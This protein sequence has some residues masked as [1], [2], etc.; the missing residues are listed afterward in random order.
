MVVYN[1]FD[2]NIQ[3]DNRKI[4]NNKINIF[5]WA[6]FRDW[7]GHSFLVKVIKKINKEN[8][9]FHFVA[10]IQDAESKRV[11]KALNLQIAKLDLNE[12]IEFHLDIPNH[13]GFIKNNAQIALSCS[14]LKDPLPTIL[15]ESLCLGIPI[16]STN[17][18]GS[19]E[20]LRAFPNFLSSPN[21]DEFSEKLNCIIN[22][23]DSY[24]R[25][26]IIDEFENR[27]RLI[28]YKEKI[29]NL[30]ETLN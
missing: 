11:H 13:L 27:F 12:F 8:V 5:F 21:I 3:N 6:Q 7:K 4:D 23:L 20:I 15:I 30:I 25:K 28:T 9:K 22:S 26:L 2:F 16:L 19:V 10:N 29:I 17:L 14:T 18:G 24:S 1:G